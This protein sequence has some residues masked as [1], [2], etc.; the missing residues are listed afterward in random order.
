[1]RGRRN[2]TLPQG[3]PMNAHVQKTADH[4]SEYKEHQRPKMKRHSRPIV[5]VENRS[6]HACFAV[7]YPYTFFSRAW[8]ITSI[9]AGFSLPKFTALAA[10]ENSIT[11][12][13]VARK[14]PRPAAL[15]T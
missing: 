11:Q 8:R 4:R 5:R 1:M 6:K 3:H 12:T 10:R 2:H 14:H 15:H 9:G 13:H 7:G